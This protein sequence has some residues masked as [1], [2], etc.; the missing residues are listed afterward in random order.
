MN[1]VKVRVKKLD[2]AAKLPCYAHDTDA[3]ADIF[4][5]ETVTVFPGQMIPIRCG[6]AVEIPVGYEIQVRSKSGL[7]A[8]HQLFVLNSP[9]TVDADYRG[10]IL[11]LMQNAGPNPY[12][13]DEGD[14]I[15]Q[16]VVGP[17]YHG[18]FEEVEEL[19][20]TVRGE[21]GFGSTGQ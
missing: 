10:E 17:V 2:P 11:V 14:K 20:E 3:G 21:G 16:F 15:A 8:K 13:F 12:C 7:A 18:D 19:S 6:I 5:L 1:S 4:S 9:G